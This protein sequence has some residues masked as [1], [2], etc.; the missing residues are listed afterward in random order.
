MNRRK[1]RTELESALAKCVIDSVIEH[2]PGLRNAIR[3]ALDNGATPAEMKRRF[4][5]ASQR[6]K[7]YV[8]SAYNT[9]LT[10]DWIVDEYEREHGLIKDDESIDEID[11]E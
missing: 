8:E 10:V 11:Y 2:N 6:K 3:D 1:H 9:A 5:L 7:P 4:G